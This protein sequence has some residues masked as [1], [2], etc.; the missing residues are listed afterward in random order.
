MDVNIWVAI[1]SGV[2]VFVAAI[3]PAIASLI[4]NR[5]KKHNEYL[6]RK[7]N[8]AMNDILY[9]TEVCDEYKKI[10]KDTFQTDEMS[11]IRKIVNAE[12]NLYWSGEFS[13]SRIK[14][15]CEKLKLKGPE[16]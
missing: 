3:I 12:R 6:L 5:Q 2:F 10:C 15:L 8:L 16:S 11:T 14:H 13:P 4:N 9:L 1:I 7:L